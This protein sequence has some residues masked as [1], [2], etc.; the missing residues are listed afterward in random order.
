MI[1]ALTLVHRWL[2]V[3][4]RLPL[5]VVFARGVRIVPFPALGEGERVAGLAP[6]DVARVLRGPR[7]AVAA[8]GIADAAR[9]RLVQRG[10]GPVYVVSGGSRSAAL[11]A[12]D[13]R[14]A[15]VASASL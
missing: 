9:V 15:G 7:E 11:R 2:G 10:D 3:P 4:C 6:L 13:I 14:P 12:D 1:R 8:S 5:A